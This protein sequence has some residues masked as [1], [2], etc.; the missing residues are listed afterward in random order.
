M[1]VIKDF[2]HIVYILPNR[3]LPQLLV[4]RPILFLVIKYD[5]TKLNDPLVGMLAAWLRIKYPH[6]VAGAIAASAP[7]AQE[8]FSLSKFEDIESPK[9]K[10]HSRDL[11]ICFMFH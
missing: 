11:N 4:A 7:V 1:K 6:L 3:L 5:L 10:I 9:S 8:T 2:S